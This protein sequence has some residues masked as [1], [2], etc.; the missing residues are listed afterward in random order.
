[1]GEFQDRIEI[2]TTY[3][4]RYSKVA[5]VCSKTEYPPRE[6]STLLTH[7]TI[8]LSPE[9]LDNFDDMFLMMMMQTNQWHHQAVASY[10]C[11]RVNQP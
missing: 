10:V 1:L 4:F 11:Q 9:V 6:P 8:V 5:V 3:N 2:L 7:D